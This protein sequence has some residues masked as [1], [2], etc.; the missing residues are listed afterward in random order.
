MQAEQPRE[1]KKQKPRSPNKARNQEKYNTGSA[2]T[3]PKKSRSQ[4]SNIY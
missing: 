4:G 2:S 3:K 1:N